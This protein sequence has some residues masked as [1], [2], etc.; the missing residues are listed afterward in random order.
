MILKLISWIRYFGISKSTLW[1]MKFFLFEK[2]WC[3]ALR[4]GCDQKFHSLNK[5]ISKKKISKN[6]FPKYS[7]KPWV[8]IKNMF[9]HIISHIIMFWTIFWVS[10]VTL[11]RLLRCTIKGTQC[12]SPSINDVFYERPLSKKHSDRESATEILMI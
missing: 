12:P 7:Y 2:I 10:G 4:M 1:L 6:F 11:L 8:T 5:I 3:W 9:C